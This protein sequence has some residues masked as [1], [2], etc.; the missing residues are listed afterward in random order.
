MEGVLEYVTP[1][2]CEDPP[3]PALCYG[4]RFREEMTKHKDNKDVVHSEDGNNNDQDTLKG[5]GQ[6]GGDETDD[7]LACDGGG[8]AKAQ[9]ASAYFRH[10]EA[11]KI[12]LHCLPD[13]EFVEPDM[14]SAPLLLCGICRQFREIVLST[15]ELWS[16]LS[17]DLGWADDDGIEE[18]ILRWLSRARRN[19]LSLC[20]SDPEGMWIS[21]SA[22]SIMQTVVGLSP[23]WRNIDLNLAPNWGK[24][25]VAGEVGPYNVRGFSV[26]ISFH[27]APKLRQWRN[28]DLNLAPNW[29]DSTLPLGGNFP[30]LE[31]LALTMLD[32]FSVRIS[33][34]DAPKLR[35]FVASVYHPLQSSNMQV[36]WHQITT[37]RMT[38]IALSDCLAILRDGTNVVVVTFDVDEDS[39]S[40]IQPIS[41]PPLV[42][43]H[44]L[45]VLRSEGLG[46]LSINLLH[47]LTAPALKNLTLQFWHVGDLDISPFISFASWSSFQLYT[48]VLSLTLSTDFIYIARSLKELPSLAYLKIEITCLLWSVFVLADRM[49]TVFHLFIGDH[50][51]LPNLESLHIIITDL[52]AVREITIFELLRWRWAARGITRLFSFHLAHDCDVPVLDEI[53]NS[54]SEFQRLAAEGMDLYFGLHQPN[55][56]W[57]YRA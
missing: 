43:L 12:F 55:I 40:P 54:S 22:W 2:C 39:S 3:P 47:F 10:V 8:P 13:V 7:A 16:S 46:Q 29:L 42:H 5:E 15:P 33:I 1:N 9:P 34:H 44:S 57:V 32:G 18:G 56:N 48:L 14:T 38:R 26:R 50:T 30:L 19:P 53:V 52:V 35:Q 28:I 4:L 45:N 6:A 23:Q 27:D 41:L 37:L 24:L 20:L 51:F 36:P 25:P 11:E 21:D 31:K 49:D 17:F